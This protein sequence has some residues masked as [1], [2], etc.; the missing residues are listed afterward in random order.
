MKLSLLI[1]IKICIL[2]ADVEV[3]RGNELSSSYSSV[4]RTSVIGGSSG[5]RRKV[6]RIRKKGHSSFEIDGDEDD[7]SYEVIKKTEIIVKKGH[8]TRKGKGSHSDVE[9]EYE[10][11]DEGENSAYN[12][13]LSMGVQSIYLSSDLTI[14]H[15]MPKAATC[16]TWNG[17]KVK[18][19]DGLIYAH[20]LRFSHTL[21]QDKI[22]GTFGIVLRACPS[23]SN[24]PIPYVLEIMMSNTKYTLQNMSE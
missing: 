24:G 9:Y 20:N 12:G 14:K 10:E 2:G 6:K 8:K 22:D 1:Q 3:V 13:M 11:Y 19:F 15:R 21:V 7:G 16:I 5:G 18:T 23:D 4:N 17:Y